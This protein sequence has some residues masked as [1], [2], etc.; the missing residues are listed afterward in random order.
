VADINGKPNLCGDT[1]NF[2]QRLMDAAN[3][4]QVLLSESAFR[5]YVGPANKGGDDPF[6]FRFD[7]PVPITAKH[8][9]QIQVYPMLVNRA[10]PYWS[11]DEPDSRHW[12][13]VSMTKI[14]H[15]LASFYDKLMESSEIAF[16]IATGIGI[17]KKYHDCG[18]RVES[19]IND[20]LEK[21]W[22]FMADEE[23]Y[24]RMGG[25]SVDG[26][27][28]P[29]QH[30][31]EERRGLF[32]RL[33][34][35]YPG[36]ELLFGRCRFMGCHGSYFNWNKEDSYIYTY[37]YVWGTQIPDISGYILA[38]YEGHSS[39]QFEQYKKGLIHL[40]STTHSW[41]NFTSVGDHPVLFTTSSAVTRPG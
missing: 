13:A 28:M 6:P 11:N 5:E 22:V 7:N 31:V 10:V 34:E 3:P 8:G 41:D 24:E 35:A 14:S 38:R 16:V 12:A 36:A 25:A 23:L 9:L 20:K 18:E 30:Y 1:I 27:T 37:P 4:R 33:R 21:F 19:F 29:F 32:R 2:A 39:E 40:R 15:S 26:A 17:L